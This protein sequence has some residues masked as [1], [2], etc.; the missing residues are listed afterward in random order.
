[1]SKNMFVFVVEN[2]NIPKVC[3]GTAETVLYTK[4]ETRA[5]R[6]QLKL[7]IQKYHNKLKL[8]IQKYH[9]YSLRLIISKQN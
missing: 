1:M 4:I 8:Q 9:N 5:Y 2:T 6:N 3:M 7:Q